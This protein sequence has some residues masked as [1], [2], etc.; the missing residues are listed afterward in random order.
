MATHL[1]E[2]Q[3][4]TRWL[5]ESRR[6][7]QKYRRSF[8]VANEHIFDGGAA[9][10]ESSNIGNWP[11]LKMAS[12]EESVVLISG[13]E[14]HLLTWP[15]ESPLMGL[16]D[17]ARPTC[18]LCQRHDTHCVYGALGAET[19]SQAL[20]RKHNELSTRLDALTELYHTLRSKPENDAQG[21]LQQIR[22]GIDPEALLNRIKESDLLIQLAVAPPTEFCYEFPFLVNMP[23]F[24]EME[25]N[26]YVT[27]KLYEHTAMTLVKKKPFP[28]GSPQASSPSWERIYR[29]PYHACRLAEP[30]VERVKPSDWTRVSSNDNLLKRLLETFFLFEFPF[31]SFFHKDFFLRDMASGSDRFC[32]SLM[33]NA[34][35]ASACHGYAGMSNRADFWEP[36]SMGYQF[37]AET[38]RLWEL[39][40]GRSKI[41][42]VQAGGILCSIV[43]ANG[44]DKV[45][46]AYLIQTIAM[47]RD[48][49]IFESLNHVK[50]KNRR[51]VYAV[52]AWSIFNLQSPLRFHFYRAPLLAVPPKEPLPD[53]KDARSS[54][55]ELY[56]KYPGSD[57]LVSFHHG[58]TTKAISEF[59]VI[60]NDISV[61]LFSDVPLR[62]PPLSLEET[63]GFRSRFLDWYVNL[64]PPLSAQ[65][66]VLP[67]HLK[68]HMHYYNVLMC[69][70]EPLL[71]A[72]SSL[73]K[74]PSEPL[75]LNA[76]GI[77][78]HCKTC[79]E[80]L[81]RLYYLR[82]G[83]EQWDSL[84]VQW[85]TV[86]GFNS[87]KDLYKP[88]LY[89]DP[90]QRNAVLST[91]LLCLK[92]LREQGLNIYIAE[93]VFT[94][95]R[96]NMSPADARPLLQIF[97]SE[98]EEERKALVAGQIRSSWPI[99]I[100]SVTDD[101]E[102]QR[103]DRLIEASAELNL[104][105]DSSSSGDL[106]PT[107]DKFD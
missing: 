45:G 49:G 22:S 103:F 43:N 58:C 73:R 70:F 33:V 3:G 81:V 35:L 88:D 19:H 69:L 102:K 61:R 98:L 64:P 41:T 9:V 13:H 10:Y 74:I 63:L 72:P 46:D 71:E 82:H 40:C 75:R 29:I 91:V 38:K 28:G 67:S 100:N 80:L 83:F 24:L 86:Q 14:A 106:S 87:I 68:I 25:S 2:R 101:P 16:C 93:A 94:V 5:S 78:N 37:L 96:A 26:P 104:Q 107:R 42:T 8:N 54:Y 105:E 76:E 48:M 56:C 21:I 1:R 36:H 44:M 59:R 52:T 17:A 6:L 53:Y 97:D 85:L 51:K 23:S 57:D 90:G 34:V 50:N 55:G 27:S 99:N 60:M 4:F 31:S 32:S 89:R 11:N 47:A 7:K 30:L 77:V 95:M 65:C 18:F 79:L 15:G 39:E 84:L 62:R 12:L 66:A 20:K 92:G